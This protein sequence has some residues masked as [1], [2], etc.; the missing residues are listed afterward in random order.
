MPVLRAFIELRRVRELHATIE[1]KGCQMKRWMVFLTAM[2]LAVAVQADRIKSTTIACPD[3]KTFEE[4]EQ[5]EGDFK[6]KNLYLMQKGCVVLTPKDKIHILEPDSNCCGIYY[7]I[8][9]DAT[10]DIMYVRKYNVYV[11]QSGTGNIFRF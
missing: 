2:S 1:K 4:I 3:I 6:N 5:K 11:E 8:Q 9:I 7:R 10:N